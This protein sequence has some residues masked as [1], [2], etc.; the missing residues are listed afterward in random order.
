[1][2]RKDTTSVTIS[3][4]AAERLRTLANAKAQELQ[5]SKLSLLDYVDILT[6]QETKRT[7]VA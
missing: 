6:S 5:L 4:T 1:M 3:R 7:K 2:P